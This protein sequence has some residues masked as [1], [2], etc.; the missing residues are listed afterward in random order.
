MAIRTSARRKL[1]STV[2]ATAALVLSS[3]V[4]TTTMAAPALAAAPC[5]GG[6][7]AIPVEGTDPTAPENPEDQGQQ[8]TL[9]QMQAYVAYNEGPYGLAGNAHVYPDSATPPNPTVGIGFNL[10]R[11]GARETI[12][13][14]GA[15]YDAVRAGTQNLTQFQITTLFVNDWNAA[16]KTLRTAIPNFDQLSSA[17]QVVLIDMA[18]AMGGAKFLT[19]KKM[20][21]AVNSGEWN[22][23]GYEIVH[24]DWASQVGQRAQKNQ[25]LMTAGAVCRPTDMPKKTTATPRGGNSGG[26][27]YPGGIYS[28]PLPGGGGIRTFWVVTVC[29]ITDVYQVRD[30]VP[31]YIG[32][33]M[34]CSS[35]AT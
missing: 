20:I 23:A 29:T 30:G 8:M 27:V 28:E 17:R 12:T 5:A 21:A 10:N 26:T 35:T 25:R 18:F 11:A 34:V 15:D 4:A 2:I 9:E 31:V 3:L 16:V 7:M 32:S 14:V 13:A 22:A 6:G 24:S 1:L 19:F 33:N